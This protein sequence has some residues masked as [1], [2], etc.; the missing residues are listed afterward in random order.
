MAGVADTHTIIE[1]DDHIGIY[2][3]LRRRLLRCKY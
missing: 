1:T 2:E 3:A